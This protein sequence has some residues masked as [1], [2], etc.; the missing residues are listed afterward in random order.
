MPRQIVFAICAVLSLCLAATAADAQQGRMRPQ[1]K[2]LQGPQEP[3]QLE[4][5]AVGKV[6]EIPNTETIR[7]ALDK[8]GEFTLDNIRVPVQF[9]SQAMAYLRKRILNK[10]V[11]LYAPASADGNYADAHGKIRVHVMTESARWVQAE[12]ISLG[13]AYAYSTQDRPNLVTALYKTETVAR[14]KNVGIWGNKTL[15]LKNSQTIADGVGS[16]QVY[17]GM[18]TEVEKTLHGHF[19]TFNKDLAGDL[20]AF[21]DKAHAL[22]IQE[23]IYPYFLNT[24]KGI[25]VR[26]HGWVENNN[27]PVMKINHAQQIEILSDDPYAGLFPPAQ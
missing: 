9:S 13:I 6:T 20:R 23:N 24:L 8:G 27:G 26:L 5:I 18:I 11:G 1:I 10:T 3:T 19:I 21:I 17:E 7:L 12:M 4:L 25:N 22:E 14:F 16:F 2:M 15:M